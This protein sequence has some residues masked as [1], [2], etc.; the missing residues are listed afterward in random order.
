MHSKKVKI[1]DEVI[2]EMLQLLDKGPNMELLNPLHE[3]VTKMC[4]RL[5]DE[6]VML[7]KEGRCIIKMN[8]WYVQKVGGK[9][10]GMLIVV[11]KN[12]KDVNWE[13]VFF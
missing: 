6:M 1:T 8:G 3:G 7:G 13:G 4:K 12:R 2:S 9:I 10:V 11:A 5:V